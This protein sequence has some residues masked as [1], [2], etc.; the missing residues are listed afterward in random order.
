LTQCIKEEPLAKETSFSNKSVKR[1]F[2]LTF[3]LCIGAGAGAGATRSCIILMEPEPYLD[4]SPAAN[5]ILKTRKFLKCR[6]LPQGFT[7]AIHINNFKNK[8]KNYKTK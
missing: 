3:Y 7:K 5:L 4:V 6:K 8:N 2:I 1:F